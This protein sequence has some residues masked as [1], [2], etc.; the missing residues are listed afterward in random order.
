VFGGFVFVG[1]SVLLARGLGATGTERER[2]LELLQVQA[3]GSANGVLAKLP[4]CATEPACVTTVRARAAKL[5]R[6]G[7]VEILNFQPSVRLALRAG[8]ALPLV[9]C[10]RVERSS[11]LAGGGVRL[12]AISG[13]IGLESACTP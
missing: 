11:A 7:P 12:I 5:A 2:V 13:P 9:Q 8:K 3:R 1:I 6:P 10:V 4:Q